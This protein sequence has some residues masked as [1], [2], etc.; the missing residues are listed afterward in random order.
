MVPEMHADT[1]IGAV[2]ELVDKLHAKGA[3]SDS[4]RFLQA[5]LQRDDLQSSCIGKGMA[6][7]HA[8][9]SAVARLSMAV[10]KAPK[11]ISYP[12]SDKFQDVRMIF[13][14]AVPAEAADTYLSLIGMLASA[15]NNA[16]IRD[17]L[18]DADTASDIIRILSPGS[19]FKP[20]Q[21]G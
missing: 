12:S 14:V 17:R 3:V 5:V 1:K 9:S 16:T 4:L 10:G 13:L 21:K 20:P 8:R 2:K 7:P 6:L 11:T 15:L 18:S 19:I